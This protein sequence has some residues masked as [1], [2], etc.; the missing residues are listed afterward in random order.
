MAE[1]THEQEIAS[2]RRRLAELGEER[3]V[4]EAKLRELLRPG[5]FT[6]ASPTASERGGVIAASPAAAK[7]ALFRDLFTGRTDVFPVRWEN[8]RAGRAGYA[9]ACANKWVTGVCGKPRV[10]CGGC[11]NQ[12]FIPVSD[13]V[14]ESHLR[15]DD[16]GRPR[17]GGDR[18]FVAG[19][20]PLLTDETCRFLAADF[21]GES[22]ARDALAYLE[23]CRLQ[24]VPAALER[25]RSG[26]GGHARGLLCRACPRPGGTAVRCHAAHRDDGAPTGDRV[27]LL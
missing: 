27:R 17:S 9:P 19:I 18:D 2:I 1:R 12:A 15:G 14:V 13:G 24:A 26:E 23:T 22:W 8:L 10:K 25:S 21:D 16:R 6:S 5:A 11:P 7:V 20:Y 3:A 4:L